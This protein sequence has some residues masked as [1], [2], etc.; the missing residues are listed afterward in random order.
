MYYVTRI[1]RTS[2]ALKIRPV[3]NPKGP[4]SY[5]ISVAAVPVDGPKLDALLDDCHVSGKWRE[6]AATAIVDG[7]ADAS[8]Y[9]TM[10]DH[11]K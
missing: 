1:I 8:F 3:S 9:A 7:L 6:V 4:D 10:E 5:E 11:T 2:D